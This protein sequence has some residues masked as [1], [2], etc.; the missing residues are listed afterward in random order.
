MTTTTINDIG[1]VNQVYS[2]DE[3]DITKQLRDVQM[4]KSSEFHNLTSLYI[5]QST[6]GANGSTTWQVLK[7]FGHAAT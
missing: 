1:E 6:S 3:D 5:M 7:V 2:D 4:C